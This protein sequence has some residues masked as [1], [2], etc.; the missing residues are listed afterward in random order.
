MMRVVSL[1]T[2]KL[3]LNVGNIRYNNLYNLIWKVWY[4]WKWFGGIRWL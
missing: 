4:K 1:I 3:H 2:K